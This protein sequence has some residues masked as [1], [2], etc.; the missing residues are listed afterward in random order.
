MRCPS[1]V[2]IPSVRKYPDI[3]KPYDYSGI[4]RMIKVNNWGYLRFDGI[5]I[6]LS[7]TM[8][9]TYLEIRP[10]EGDRFFVCYR[11]YKI[12]EIDAVEG[13]LLNR[14]ISRLP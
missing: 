6:Y 4:Y 13:K 5:Q 10:A 12:A 11:N 8:A 14:R 3:I 9:D 7:E 1:D 2:Y